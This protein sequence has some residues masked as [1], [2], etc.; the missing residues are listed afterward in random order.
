MGSCVRDRTASRSQDKQ[1]SKLREYLS[2]TGVSPSFL[3]SCS[4]HFTVALS[5]EMKLVYP[6]MRTTDWGRRKRKEWR[7]KNRLVRSKHWHTHYT[8]KAC[9]VCLHTNVIILLT[10]KDYHSLSNTNLAIFPFLTISFFS[11]C[12]PF[13]LSFS[14]SVCLFVV[15]WRS[16]F[17]YHLHYWSSSCCHT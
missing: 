2:I 10:L 3:L 7:G 1:N 12:L 6:S 4:V 11:L 14:L 8:E 17:C 16:I 9:K 13:S 5:P 15:M